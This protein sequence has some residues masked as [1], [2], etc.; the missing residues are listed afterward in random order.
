MNRIFVCCLLFIAARTM[1]QPARYTIANSHSHNDYEQAVPFWLAY[2]AGFGSIEADIF[3]K[4]GVLLVGHDTVEIRAGRTLEEFYI[5]P[6]LTGLRQHNG[7]PYADS[8]RSLQMLIDVKTNGDTTLD[9]LIALLEKYPAL[10]GNRAVRWTI[11]G[12]RPDPASWSAYP[13]FISFDG[14]LSAD[15]SAEALRRIVMMSDDLKQYTHWNGKGN[16]PAQERLLLVEAITRAHRLGKPVR[17][18]DAPDFTDAWDQLV[19][20]GVDY[21]NTDHIRALGEYLHG[22]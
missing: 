5:R 20:L 9:A 15:Y 19:K 2:N 11:T 10:I 12:N 14:I 4:D 22:L 18:W 13:P 17:F 3:L 1:A 7:H 16:I 21:I 6:L 8:T